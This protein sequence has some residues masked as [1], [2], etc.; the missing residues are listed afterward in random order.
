MVA[1]VVYLMKEQLK[2][3]FKFLKKFY[4]MFHDKL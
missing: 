3:C 2:Q 4:F 1:K